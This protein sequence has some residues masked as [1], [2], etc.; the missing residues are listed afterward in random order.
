VE[1]CFVAAYIPYGEMSFS[2]KDGIGT[3]NDIAQEQ[4][5]F[6]WKLV[7]RKMSCGAEESG[8]NCVSVEI[9]FDLER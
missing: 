6:K 4:D 9:Q 8:A 1:S 5:A 3:E 7:K 2:W